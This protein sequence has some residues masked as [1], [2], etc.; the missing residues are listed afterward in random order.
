MKNIVLLIAG[1]ILCISI[2]EAQNYL[3]DEFSD[4][5]FSMS[6][7]EFKTIKKNISIPESMMD[8]RIEVI[9]N[10]PA[11][12]I[13][14]ITYYFDAEGNQSL[15]ELIIDYKS[16][17]KRDQVAAQLL[18]TPNYNGKEWRY[19][20]QNGTTIWAW[21]YM[22]KLIIVAVLKGTEWEGEK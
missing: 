13:H 16:A 9:E 11:K 14:E 4:L 8:F 7:E 2:T 18:K 19:T 6:L 5:R 1:C 20:D 17:A 22:N 3:P 12:G 21:T 15:Y 10:K